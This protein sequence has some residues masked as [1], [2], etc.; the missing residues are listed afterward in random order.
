ME[1]NDVAMEGWAP[2][3]EGKNDLFH[4]DVLAKHREGRTA[5][6]SPRWCLRWLLQRGII[7]IPKSVKTRTAC[8]QNFDV[9]DFALTDEEMDAHQRL[10][11]RAR[12]AFFD[13]RDPAGRRVSA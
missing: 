1:K 13:H 7:C 9:F 6:A 10:S 8:E 5:R 12:V 2:F 4:N 3:A 11:T